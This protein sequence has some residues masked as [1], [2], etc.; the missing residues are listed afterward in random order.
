MT[1]FVLGSS[2]QASHTPA[3]LRDGELRDAVFCLVMRGEWMFPLL[4]GDKGVCYG[5]GCSRGRDYFAAV[6]RCGVS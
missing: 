3:P 1:A 6:W 5:E 2:A 4:R